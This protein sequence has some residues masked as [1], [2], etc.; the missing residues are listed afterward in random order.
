MTAQLFCYSL[1][2]R[3]ARETAVQRLVK[4]SLKR[5]SKLLAHETRYMESSF[6]FLHPQ[7]GCKPAAGCVARLWQCSRSRLGRLDS[8]SVTRWQ[9]IPTRL[10]VSF[11]RTA[12]ES[13]PLLLCV[14]ECWHPPPPKPGWQ[15]VLRSGSAL[16][17]WNPIMQ[18]SLQTL[19]D[20][21]VAFDLF[22]RP[23]KNL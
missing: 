18:S 7:R 6:L 21:L 2:L 19:P 1:R 22:I 8:G 15:D 16:R 10:L 9:R 5:R 14:L 20:V 4:C 3:S 23:K 11:S 13:T 12:L 17:L